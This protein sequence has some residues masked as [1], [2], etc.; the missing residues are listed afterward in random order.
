MKVVL[1]N[2]LGILDADGTRVYYGPGE[3]DLPEAYVTALGLEPVEQPEP[4]KPA[5]KE[6]AKE[7]E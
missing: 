3:A 7:A 6:A 2:T 5:K 4:K 1:K